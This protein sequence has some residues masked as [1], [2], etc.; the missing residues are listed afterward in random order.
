M[1]LTLVCLNA[2]YVHASIAPWCLKAGVEK[3][4]PNTLVRVVEATVNEKEEAVLER[5]LEED[6]EL[7]GFCTYIWNYNSVKSLVKKIK[8][9]LPQTSIVLG[10]PE[11]G[12]DIQ[13]TFDEIAECD[14]L[15][16]GAGEM[17]LG[18]LCK[19]LE[20]KSGFDKVPALYTRSSAPRVKAV[21]LE[22]PSPY[23][24][25]YL[26][27][28]NGRMAY[29]ETM[30]GCPNKCAFCVSGREEGLV[31]FDMERVK[32]DIL[33]VA[34]SSAKTVKFVDR[35]F[36][37]K[38]SRAVEIIEFIIRSRGECYPK[39]VCFHFELEAMM[40]SDELTEL[41]C[42]A[43]QGLFRLEVGIQSFNE[44]TLS[45]L[46]RRC[47]E[48]KLCE[49]VKR[50]CSCKALTVHLDLIAGLVY[51]DLESFADS[52]NKTFALSPDE[53]QLGFLKL[54][55]GTSVR[56]DRDSFPCEYAKEPPYEVQSTPWLNGEELA[57][58]RRVAMCVEKLFNS[59][60]FEVSLK[61]ALKL[62]RTPFDFFCEFAS[63]SGIRHGMSL[64]DLSDTFYSYLLNKGY[65]PQCARDVLVM[66]RLA[67]GA[68]RL[69]LLLKQ[70]DTLR[71]KPKSIVKKYFGEPDG[72]RG[73][74]VLYSKGLVAFCDYDNGRFCKKDPISARYELFFCNLKA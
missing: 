2:K 34:N 5:I 8:N 6:F 70:A 22:M 37:A 13:N 16:S 74:A 52:F 48:K 44:K 73:A 4:S 21:E 7:I 40:L 61:E 50:L 59:H 20:D 67:V 54:L 29:I 23:C 17:P 45:A 39:D 11:V 46:S 28:L 10:G 60:R 9:V 27:K 72:R 57:L 32:R 18:L 56:E 3:Y 14:F 24:D 64:D 42:S 66:D 33:L 51:E 41:F 25:E 19:A 31:F 53:L 63:F 30:R 12:F 49:R 43:P 38:N 71:L 58:L 26:E 68:D 69:S 55:K 35:S 36:N 62:S 47:D 15:I 65:D 1:K